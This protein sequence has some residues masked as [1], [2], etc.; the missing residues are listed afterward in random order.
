[1]IFSTTGYSNLTGV[2][3]L[4]FQC[5]NCG[6][7]FDEN[8]NIDLQVFVGPTNIKSSDKKQCTIVQPTIFHV[9]SQSLEVKCMMPQGENATVPIQ[10]QWGKYLSPPYAV[11]YRRPSIKNIL[12]HSNLPNKAEYDF[13]NSNYNPNRNGSKMLHSISHENRAKCFDNP[14]NNDECACQFTEQECE[15]INFCIWD[16]SRN[17]CGL[18]IPTQ[19]TNISIFGANFGSNIEFVKV[20]WGNISLTLFSMHFNHSNGVYEI[21]SHLPAGVSHILRPLKMQVNGQMS[22]KDYGN[23]DSNVF[24]I[25]HGH[26]VISSVDLGQNTRTIGGYDIFI[27][28]SNFGSSKKNIMVYIG[29]RIAKIQTVTHSVIAILAA[30]GQGRGQKIYAEVLREKTNVAAKTFDY[31]APRMYFLRSNL[32]LLPTSGLTSEGKPVVATLHGDNFGIGRDITIHFGPMD[33]NIFV[34]TMDVDHV[35]INLTVPPGEGLN[36]TISINVSGQVGV[37]DKIFVNY[38]KPVIHSIVS[39]EA[40]GNYDE[41]SIF[42]TSG[43]RMFEPYTRAT[44]VGVI[45]KERVR[46]MIYGKNFGRPGRNRVG[47]K[48]LRV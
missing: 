21:K 2:G 32:M 39:A 45:C 44:K 3:H 35:Q 11:A 28:G 18:N 13:H 15:F 29:G 7:G 38:D 22:N 12:L 27:Y 20:Y 23:L 10:L 26:P 33:K 25:R 4:L 43:C 9:D 19:G 42:P 6:S 30:P 36:L 46:L 5:I 31:S 1:M 24:Y 17:I 48:I 34:Q 40:Q 8:G 47:F 37:S 14:V 41:F 16:D